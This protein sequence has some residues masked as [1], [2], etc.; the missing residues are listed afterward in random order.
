MPY[1]SA[2][3]IRGLQEP[4]YASI[5]DKKSVLVDRTDVVVICDGSNSGETFIG[6]E[7]ILSSTM[8][9]LAFNQEVNTLF[10]NHFLILIMKKIKSNRFWAAIPHLDIKWLLSY[11]IPL[12]PLPT[13][14]LIVQKLDSSFEKIDKSIEL[15]KENLKNLEELNKSVLEKVFSEWEYE[16][17]KL[18]EICDFKNWYAFKSNE[19]NEKWNWLQVIRIWNVLNLDKNIVFINENIKFNEFKLSK[20]D[21]IIGLTWTRQKR[22]YLL[23]GIIL[24]DDK[25]YLNQRVLRL[26][27]SDK[28]SY[29]FLYFYLKTDLFRNK[30]FIYETWT[31]NQWN[32]SWKDIWNQKIPL[33]PLEKQKEI[34]AYLDDI[35]EKNKQLKE[36]Y[37]KKL[38]DL[39]GM[40]QTL[41]K[42]AF[43]GRLVKE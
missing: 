26:R 17:K 40:K 42:E 36:S 12:P 9:K 37:E 11:T 32:L 22:D 25:Y 29:K 20:N 4:N 34:V 38:K 2:K 27:V 33:P 39:E 15:T 19:F 6:L 10:I 28:L 5:S 31:V 1:L 30:I 43:E 35:F 8:W 41:L 16:I 3:Y 18:W 21:I 23:P 14:K 24:E 7:W 13:Q